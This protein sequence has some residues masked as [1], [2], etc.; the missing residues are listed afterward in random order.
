MTILQLN[1]MIPVYV[2]DKGEGYA[3]AIIDYSQEHHILWIVAMSDTGEVWTVPNPK[4]RLQW[5]YSVERIPMK[6]EVK[7]SDLKKLEKKIMKEDRKEDNKLY[8]KKS[9]RKNK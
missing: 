5:N 3:I 2:L 8:M 6:K 7:K 1:P 9:K 4:L